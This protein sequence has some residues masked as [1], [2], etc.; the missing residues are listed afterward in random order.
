[1][2][3]VTLDRA[4]IEAVLQFLQQVVADIHHDDVVLLAGQGGEQTTADLPRAEDNDFHGLNPESRYKRLFY[5][6]LFLASPWL[7]VQH[8]NSP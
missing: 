5:L 4:N 6:Y 3:R 1:M 2:G 7:N 8:M